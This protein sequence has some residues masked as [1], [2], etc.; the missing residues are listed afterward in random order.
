MLLP[1][2]QSV[3]LFQNR[4]GLQQSNLQMHRHPGGMNQGAHSRYFR[5]PETQAIRKKVAQYNRLA[6][7]G[8]WKNHMQKTLKD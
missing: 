8:T 5:G 1:S 7:G 4:R 2:T 6:R 3:V